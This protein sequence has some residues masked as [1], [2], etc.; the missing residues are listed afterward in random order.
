MTSSEDLPIIRR[1]MRTFLDKARSV[2]VGRVGQNVIED[3][4]RLFNLE[5]PRGDKNDGLRS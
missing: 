1:E 4:Y 5:F 2:T 3:L